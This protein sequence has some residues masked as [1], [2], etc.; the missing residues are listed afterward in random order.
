MVDEY[1]YRGAR[2]VYIY[3]RSKDAIEADDE[4]SDAA[5]AMFNHD[6]P[7]RDGLDN[8]ELICPVGDYDTFVDGFVVRVK[9]NKS[10]D[11]LRDGW[12][13]HLAKFEAWAIHDGK[14]DIH[15]SDGFLGT[16]GPALQALRQGRLP[17]TQVF[18]IFHRAN[19]RARR[20]DPDAL[21]DAIRA[22]WKVESRAV[23]R[24]RNG[25]VFFVSSRTA[26]EALVAAM[27]PKFPKLLRPP[28]HEIA[29]D[30]GDGKSGRLYFGEGPA[31][32]EF[33]FDADDDTER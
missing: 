5:M 11:E 4:A 20:N 16:V 1:T 32:E 28:F 15:E 26:A 29:F 17:V 14:G 13:Q 18:L 7:S 9:T 25:R 3:L 23:F 19:E 2:P 8:A 21:A 12:K 27:R 22:E 30:D 31:W 10:L 33:S 24:F 6:I